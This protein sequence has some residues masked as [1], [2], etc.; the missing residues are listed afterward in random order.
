MSNNND[1]MDFLES[2]SPTTSTA[3]A[4]EELPVIGS[5]DKFDDNAAGVPSMGPPLIT[6]TIPDEDGTV[7]HGRGKLVYYGDGGRKFFGF[8]SG[9]QVTREGDKITFTGTLNED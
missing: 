9:M 2:L 7:T 1:V 5:G 6:V 3:T 4:S 8:Y